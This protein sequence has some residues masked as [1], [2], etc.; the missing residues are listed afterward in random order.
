MAKYKE[1]EI[2]LCQ[3]NEIVNNNII[4]KDQNYETHNFK[5]KI[6]YK[7]DICGEEYITGNTIKKIYRKICQKHHFYYKCDYCGKEFEI[8]NLFDFISSDKD[9]RFCSHNCSLQYRNKTDDMKQKVS[10][11]DKNRVQ[12]NLSKN[13]YARNVVKFFILFS[14]WMFVMLV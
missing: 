12:V 5:R 4:I 2:T 10:E 3:N 1:K 7:C 9:L 11:M 14:L 8:T 13:K 6:H